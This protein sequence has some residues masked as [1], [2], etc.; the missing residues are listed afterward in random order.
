MRGLKTKNPVVYRVN[1][2]YKKKIK[3]KKME[4]Y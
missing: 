4:L 1:E 2:F 3:N